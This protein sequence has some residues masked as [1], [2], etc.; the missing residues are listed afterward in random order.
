MGLII[1]SAL[2]FCFSMNTLGACC[3]CAGLPPPGMDGIDGIEG[4]KGIA[5]IGCGAPPG[6]FADWPCMSGRPPTIGGTP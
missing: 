2:L 3:C 6:P 4:M 1:G 5:P